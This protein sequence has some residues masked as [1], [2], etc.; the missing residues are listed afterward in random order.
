MK[1]NLNLN[2]QS[3]LATSLKSKILN[4]NNRLLL[5]IGLWGWLIFSGSAIA[6]TDLYNWQLG[7]EI[8]PGIRHAQLD[9]QEPRIMKINAM[10][11]DLSNPQLRFTATSKDEDWGKPMPDYPELTIRTKRQ[12][13][14]D[15]MLQSRERGL[16]MILA[17]NSNGWQPWTSPFTHTYADNLGLIISD[18]VVVSELRDRPSLIVYK[19]G[20]ITF[21]IVSPE[22]DL[23]QIQTA[24]TGFA[25]VLE[26]GVVTSKDKSNAP[27]TGYGLSKHNEFLILLT[28]DGRQKGYSEG[29]S[30]AEVAEWLR[31]FGAYN[32]L[33]MDGGG[34]TTLVYWDAENSVVKKVNHQSGN[35]ERNVGCNLGI[36]LAE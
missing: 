2:L 18:G 30:T 24:V 4:T 14:R 20:R 7:E 13:T 15:F 12:K 10:Q 22:D 8:Y 9:V 29:A 27:R 34:S 25:Y 16:N 26:E 17:I 6:Q 5:I 23:S 33:N 28:I 1:R 36:Y 35:A 11:V 32:G 21:G 19:D 31:Y 3:N